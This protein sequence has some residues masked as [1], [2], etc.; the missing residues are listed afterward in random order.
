MRGIIAFLFVACL[1]KSCGWIGG[2]YQSS[3][4]SIYYPNISDAKICH[5][6]RV[7]SKMDYKIIDTI[8][9]VVLKEINHQSVTL[10][11]SAYYLVKKFQR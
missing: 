5:E 6:I 8:S 7:D 4:L 11:L 1:I 9:T 3:S 10:F 2:P